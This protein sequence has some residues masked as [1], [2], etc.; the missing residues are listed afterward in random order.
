MS[1]L[2][3]ALTD[4]TAIREQLLAGSV[5]QGFGPL[6]MAVTAVL[7]AVG[8]LLQSLE[9]APAAGTGY[10][11]FWLIIAAVAAAISVVEALA[12][13]HRRHG[14]LA[15][16]LLFAAIERFIPSLVAGGAI[17]AAFLMGAPDLLWL[18]PGI[19]QILVALGLA[20]A[21]RQL[22]GH[23]LIAAAWYLLCGIAVLMIAFSSRSL[24][25]AMMGLPFL[26][27]QLLVAG[28][29]RFAEED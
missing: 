5:Y 26:G 7:A 11:L 28:L 29:L 18:L 9:V 8:W 10:I 23:L 4:I 16:K 19:W 22:P 3:R 21:A 25:P 12:R 14:G 24:D 27:G 2:N 20:A 13:G 15:D 1:D 6:V 17:T